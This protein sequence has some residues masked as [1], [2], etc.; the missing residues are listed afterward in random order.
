M[1]LLKIQ[2][3]QLKKNDLLSN[4]CAREGNDVLGERKSLT[5]FETEIHLFINESAPARKKAL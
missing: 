2:K 1:G 3:R 4:N 5:S